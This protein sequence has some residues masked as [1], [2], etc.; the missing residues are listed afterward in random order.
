MTAG[1]TRPIA[2]TRTHAGIV[3]VRK[4]ALG[5]TSFLGP[6]L[7]IFHSPVGRKMIGFKHCVTCSRRGQ[8]RRREFITLLGCA[9]V[10]W[11]RAARAQQ[12]GVPVIGILAA[13]S[14]E[15]SIPEL[16]AAFGR[17]LAEMRYVVG[18]NVSIERRWAR[19]NYD[20]LPELAQELVRL[21]PALIVVGG[22]VVALA[23][24][25]SAAWI[26]PR[27]QP[28]K[29]KQWRTASADAPKRPEKGT[30]EAFEEMQFRGRALVI[31]MP[32]DRRALVDLLLYLEKN[33]SVLPQEFCGRSLAFHLLRTLRL[34]LRKSEGYGVGR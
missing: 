10:M 14:P 33:F 31:V 16:A 12:P 21:K 6:L 7:A 29:R 24:A 26:D 2:E 17:G 4:F 13:G 28:S 5:L 1:S 23:A 20:R 32:T 34:S 11:S 30:A 18:Y 22:N 8:M 15:D 25:T 19:G 9:A 27:S 3:R